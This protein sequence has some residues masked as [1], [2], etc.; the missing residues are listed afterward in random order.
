MPEESQRSLLDKEQNFKETQ[1]IKQ[2][3]R[4]SFNPGHRTFIS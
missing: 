1:N 4:Q 3:K 2:V